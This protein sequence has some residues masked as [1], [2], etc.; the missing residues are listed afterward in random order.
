MTSLT[1]D[2]DTESS[3]AAANKI[4]DICKKG[5]SQVSKLLAK[6]EN[7]Q[8]IDELSNFSDSEVKHI[9][10]ELNEIMSVYDIDNSAQ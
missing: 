10:D 6:V 1:I 5:C 2:D 4:E 3:I 8:K 9:I 7:G